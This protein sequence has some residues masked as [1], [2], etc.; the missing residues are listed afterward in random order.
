MQLA[1]V[2]FYSQKRALKK[3]QKILDLF[4]LNTSY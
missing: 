2:L 4:A 3:Q 1:E